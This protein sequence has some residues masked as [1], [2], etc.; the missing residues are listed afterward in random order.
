MTWYEKTE[1][2]PPYLVRFL[3]RKH[4]GHSSLTT[5]EIAERSGLSKSTVATIAVK[6]SWKGVAIDK[7]EAFARGCGVSFDRYW[8]SISYLKK[9]RKI[10]LIHGNAHQRKL[11]AKLMQM[12]VKP[13]K[14]A[15]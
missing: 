14:V 15:P 4:K 10:F 7:V 5:R 6:T 8:E 12:R 9:S 1:K 13:V 11:F 2:L 3:A